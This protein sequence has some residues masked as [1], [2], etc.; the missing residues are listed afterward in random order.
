MHV[1]P[2]TGRGPTCLWRRVG[3]IRRR[4]PLATATSPRCSTGFV[5]VLDV[6]TQMTEEE[7][8]DISTTWLLNQRTKKRLVSGNILHLQTPDPKV[9]PL[10]HPDLL[11]LHASISRVVRCA[12]ASREKQGDDYCGDEEEEEECPLPILQEKKLAWVV[13]GTQRR[14]EMSFALKRLLEDSVSDI[15]EDV[16]AAEM[17]NYPG[18]R[19]PQDAAGN[20]S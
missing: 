9:Y 8:E 7:D 13:K 1:H 14:P 16:R 11:R 2:H 3:S 12:G 6:T 15:E 20:T 4:F 18:R 5:A 19:M 10:P 17:A